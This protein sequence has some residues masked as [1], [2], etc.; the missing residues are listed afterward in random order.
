MI[1]IVD[2]IGDLDLCMLIGNHSIFKFNWTHIFHLGMSST[3]S[4]TYNKISNNNVFDAVETI[5]KQ[6]SNYNIQ[7]EVNSD[8]TNVWMLSA[9]FEC[10]ACSETASVMACVVLEY[11][12]Y[13][14]HSP[15]TLTYCYVNSYVG[16]KW[17]L[18]LI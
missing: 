14:L 2:N 11:V 4:S 16:Y 15:S 12:L 18:S 3:E 8:I 5:K 6:S 9:T 13:V 17:C 10:Q 1:T 7:M